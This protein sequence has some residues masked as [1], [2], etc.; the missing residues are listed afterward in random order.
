MR[1]EMPFKVV[2]DLDSHIKK[3]KAFRLKNHIPNHLEKEVMNELA[4]YCGISF[5]QIVRIK[6][7]YSQPSLGVSI[8]IA[9]FFGVHVED[10][11]DVVASKSNE[12]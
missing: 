1:K 5:N 4:K 2:N 6:H 3:T 11:F 12:N 8:L 7:N 9:E 10:L